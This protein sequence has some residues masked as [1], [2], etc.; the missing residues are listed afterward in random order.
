MEKNVL[1]PLLSVLPR[2]QGDEVRATLDRV[3]SLVPALLPGAREIDEVKKGLNSCFRLYSRLRKERAPLQKLRYTFPFFQTIWSF[4]GVMTGDE[5]GHISTVVVDLHSRCLRDSGMVARPE[6]T[7]LVAWTGS[8]ACLQPCRM[9]YRHALHGIP[10][11]RDVLK[12]YKE[13]NAMQ[14]IFNRRLTAWSA[15]PWERG[16]DNPADE[17]PGNS[18]VPYRDLIQPIRHEL[19]LDLRCFC[20]LRR[21][22]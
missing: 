14:V 1:F 15:H 12:K 16:T 3:R 20:G 21:P 2:P 18:A 7:F 13:V 10:E 9:L 19:W 11:I 5:I 8:T 6:F 17:R 22:R 4:R